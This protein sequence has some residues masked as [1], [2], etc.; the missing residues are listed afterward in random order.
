M[1]LFLPSGYSVPSPSPEIYRRSRALF[2]AF[3]SNHASM[4]GQTEGFALIAFMDFFGASKEGQ[5]VGQL[6]ALRR[7][8][9]TREYVMPWSDCEAVKRG[10][11]GN[12][13]GLDVQRCRSKGAEKEM[14][15]CGRVSYFLSSQTLE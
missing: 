6:L 7:A 14:S 10:S 3:R 15:A 13:N 1:V 5:D 2:P 8:Q 11:N 12:I 4:S 9:L